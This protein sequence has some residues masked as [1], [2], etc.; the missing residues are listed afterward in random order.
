MSVC[1]WP[2]TV[3][4]S[5]NQTIHSL[6][7]GSDSNLLAT[8]VEHKG[9]FHVVSNEDSISAV[10]SELGNSKSLSNTRCYKHWG[11]S[12]E[13]ADRIFHVVVKVDAD[14]VIDKE[15][16]HCDLRG[17]VVSVIN[18]S[19]SD[20]LVKYFLYLCGQKMSVKTFEILYRSH[21][22]S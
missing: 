5:T 14:A 13:L 12:L 6:V 11:S 16:S 4:V 21:S 20:E 8:V 15:C 3:R 17:F 22:G 10:L 19:R 7:V 9:S 18:V 1:L 2:P